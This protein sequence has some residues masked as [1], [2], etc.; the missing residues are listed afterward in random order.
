[1]RARFDLPVFWLLMALGSV[2]AIGQMT[3][4]GWGG[5]ALRFAGIILAA[6][7]AWMI[8]WAVRTM[9]GAGTPVMPGQ[10]P[11]RLVTSGPFAIS[12]NPIYLGMAGV[13][14][15]AALWIGA[16][17]A[18][19]IVPVFMAVIAKRFIQPEEDRLAQGFGPEFQRW[20]VRTGRWL[21]LSPH[22]SNQA[23]K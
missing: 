5:G 2:W 12:R 6:A 19:L 7:S 18:L 3:I 22:G 13:V 21:R 16:P 20:Q 17:L 4:A 15:A 14:G 23:L 9:R 10:E 1:M 8:L 11:A